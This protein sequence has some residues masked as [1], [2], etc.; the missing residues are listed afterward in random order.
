MADVVLPA[1]HGIIGQSPA[2]R[3][4]V[5][6]QAGQAF[7]AARLG[8]QALAVQNAA[9]LLDPRNVEIWIDRSITYA[10]VILLG[11][12][13]LALCLLGLVDTAIGLRDRVLAK[14][15]PPTRS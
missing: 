14:R 8:E 2:M 12:P 4:E 10:G 1:F 15:S 7:Q 5:Y 6:A 11:W 3:A 9:I 13:M